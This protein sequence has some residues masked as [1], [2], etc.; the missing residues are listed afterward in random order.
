MTT[1]T[2]NPKAFNLTQAALREMFTTGGPNGPVFFAQGTLTSLSNTSNAAP[3]GTPWTYYMGNSEYATAYS[4]KFAIRPNM[5][6]HYAS[7]VCIYGICI[8][9]SVLLTARYQARADQAPEF[10]LV[11]RTAF[12]AKAF[13]WS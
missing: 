2:R 8:Y 3:W 5:K 1:L 13:S 6:Y 10:R 11:G 12:I 9:G 4:G 7:T